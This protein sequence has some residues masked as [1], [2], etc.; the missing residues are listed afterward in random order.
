MKNLIFFLLAC[1]TVCS[2]FAQSNKQNNDPALKGNGEVFFLETFDWADPTDERGWSL[3]EGYYMEDPT[4][5]GFNWHWWGYDSLFTPNLT[6]EPPMESTSAQNGS[7]CLFADLYNQ[8]NTPRINVDNSIVFPPFDCSE[9]SS[10]IVRYE[11]CFMNYDDYFDM[12]LEISV[13]DW[14]HSAQFDVS[15]GA[16]H[17]GRPNQTAPGKPA[18][19]EANISNIAAGNPNVQIKITWRGTSLYWWQIDDFQLSEAYNND[20][21]LRFAEMEWN[22]GDEETVVTPSFLYPKS[23]IGDGFLTNFKS[24]AINFGE[25]DQENVFLNVDIIKNNQSVYNQSGES[26]GLWTL[27]KDTTLIEVPYAP[28]EFGHYKVDFVYNQDATDDT[29]ENNSKEIYFHVNDSVYSRGDDTSEEK[30]C[31]GLD[32]YGP[33]GEPNIGYIV[34][35]IYPI[36]TDCEVNS[37]SAYI[38]GGR[39]DGMIDFRYVLFLK[40]EADE[41]PI[42][43]TVSDFIDYDSSMIDTWVTIPLEK[44][45]ESEFLQEGDVVYAC[46]EYNNMNTDLISHRYENFK[47]GADVSRRI[48]DP[49]S[50]A[51]S[52]EDLSWRYDYYVSERNLMIRLNINDHSNIIDNVDLTVNLASLGQNYP[53]PFISTTEIAYELTGSSVV[54]IELMDL[55]GRIVMR[56]DEGLKTAGKQIATLNADGL[57]SGVYFY[58]LTAGEFSETKKLVIQ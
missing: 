36:Y 28:V 48:M 22:D 41:D 14:V 31:W 51:R 45:G 7:L 21:Q 52:G 25:Y 37:I 56:I 26:I 54:I 46:V 17:K 9:H 32:A 57:E 6:R 47:V 23:Q 13:D 24:S 2:G 39:G 3:P 49:M 43:L 12:L 15:F 42:E 55:T 11:T 19:F 30:F 38:A 1:S 58:T 44:D 8:E 16:L 18:I 29:P 33:S 27:E 40:S 35:T 5:N 10:V 4:D 50:L 20:L 34:G 53:N